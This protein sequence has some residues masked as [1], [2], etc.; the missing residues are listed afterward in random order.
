MDLFV[1]HQCLCNDRVQFHG[2]KPR[3]K[4]ALWIVILIL[5]RDDPQVAAA[6][7]RADGPESISVV[8]LGFRTKRFFNDSNAPFL[9]EIWA[10]LEYLILEV[11][12]GLIGRHV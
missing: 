4:K 8:F 6:E 10:L 9:L 12:S 11:L 7:L 1:K 2:L 3:S 5:Q